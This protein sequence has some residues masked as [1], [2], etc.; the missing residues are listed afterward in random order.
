MTC[1]QQVVHYEIL[2]PKCITMGELYGEFNPLTQEWHD[3]LASTLMRRAVAD[4]TDDRKW[5]VF[6]GP[7]DAL[8]IENMN[9]VLDDNMTLCLANG[10]RIKLKSEMKMLFEVQDLVVASPATVSRIGVVYMTSYTD[11]GWMPY[12]QTWTTSLLS[13]CSAA[14]VQHLLTLFEQY[15]QDGI[16]YQRKHCTEPVECVDVQLATSLTVILQSLLFEDAMKTLSLPEAELLQLINKLFAFAF[17]WSIGGSVS[18]S[19]WEQ[20][21]DYVRELFT[22]GG[23]KTDMPHTGSIYDYFVDPATREFKLWSTIVQPFSYKAGASY[24]AMMVPTVD[25]TRFSYLFSHLIAQNK[26]FFVGGMTGTG[27]TVM[28]QN[29]LQSL[30][31]LVEDGGQGV[32]ATTINFSAQTSSLV[33]QMSIESK[34]EKKRKNLL[35][36]PA[37]RKAIFFIDD[38]NM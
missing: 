28:V 32:M 26:P 10:E 1:N 36:A 21:D 6:D 13:K 11:L 2:N 35:G 19:N 8:W 24:F 38:V 31:P 15:V 17:I 37:G 22:K 23:L 12:V 7:I 16:D 14:T 18:D 25:T 20:M 9:T 5:T 3:G 34:L 33:T 29:L 30:E 27:K 4:T